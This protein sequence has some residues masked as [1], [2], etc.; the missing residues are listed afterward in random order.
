M[1]FVAAGAALGAGLVAKAIGGALLPRKPRRAVDVL[2][3]W[4]LTPGAIAASAAA[5][6]V[7]LAVELTVP[8]G[9]AGSTKELVGAL[10]TG[11]TT[12]ITAAFMA[13]AGD[14]K[15]STLGNEIR[16]IFFSKYTRPP[17]PGQPRSADIHYFQAESPGERWVHSFE[18]G[19]VEGWGREARRRRADGIAEELRSGESDG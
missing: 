13:W 19:G 3:W 2:E 12:F 15:D 6:V 1:A 7:I 5:V 4:A 8:E 11:L 10:S 17:D 16:D 9:T 18:Y 14:E